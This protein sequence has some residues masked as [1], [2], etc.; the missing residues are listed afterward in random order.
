MN[1]EICPHYNTLVVLSWTS[2]TQK[3]A[4]VTVDQMR[5]SPFHHVPPWDFCSWER[6]SFTFILSVQRERMKLP[7]ERNK[8]PD[9]S[10]KDSSSF[11][12]VFIQLVQFS[13]CYLKPEL[14]GMRKELCNLNEVVK[15]LILPKEDVFTWAKL[16][17]SGLSSYHF[18]GMNSPNAYQYL[19][20]PPPCPFHR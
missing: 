12:S 15:V 7:F 1:L 18:P 16:Q 14:H 2:Q 10:G 11:C 20:I 5:D 6:K 19:L 3:N 13:L 17:F 4:S 8:S 9:G